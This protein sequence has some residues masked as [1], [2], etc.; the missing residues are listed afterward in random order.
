MFLTVKVDSISQR[1]AGIIFRASFV[2]RRAERPESLGMYINQGE[3][4][5]STDSSSDIQ[6]IAAWGNGRVASIKPDDQ[7]Y[8]DD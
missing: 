8:G 2:E 4:L 5:P 1:Q 3:E 6:S 7:F